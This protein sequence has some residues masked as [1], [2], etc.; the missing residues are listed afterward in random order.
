MHVVLFTINT[1]SSNA[2]NSTRFVGKPDGVSNVFF[3]LFWLFFRGLNTNLGVER[4]QRRGFKSPTSDKSSTAGIE[5]RASLLLSRA[6]SH[7]MIYQ[8]HREGD[9]GTNDPGPKTWK[10]LKRASSTFWNKFY[11][12]KIYF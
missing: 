11:E 12:Q 9:K 1:K 8:A 3:D 4:Y 2:M 5:M 7:R 10:T 6:G